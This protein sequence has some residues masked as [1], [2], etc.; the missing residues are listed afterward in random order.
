MGL[1][2]PILKNIV[3]NGHRTSM[4]MERVYWEIL[5]EICLRE[6]LTRD[7]ML[8]MIYKRNSDPSNSEATLTSAVR[9]FILSYQRAAATECGHL[10][11]R[12]G[13]GTPMLGTPL[14]LSE[15]HVIL[16]KHKYPELLVSP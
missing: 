9:V 10:L 5:D 14:E 3:I 12:H 16:S 1:Y 11:A 15:D 2:D 6:C 7:R 8:T 13:N 4:N